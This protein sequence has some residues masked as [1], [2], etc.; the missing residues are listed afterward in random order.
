MALARDRFPLAR[1]RPISL[2]VWASFFSASRLHVRPPF[3]MNSRIRLRSSPRFR[4]SA[5]DSFL[6]PTAGRRR[7]PCRDWGFHSG[8]VRR[9]HFI[10]CDRHLRSHDAARACNA[11]QRARTPAVPGGQA[12]DASRLW[13]RRSI[14]CTMRRCDGRYSFRCCR[15]VS[16]LLTV[17][18]PRNG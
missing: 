18:S 1:R 3:G 9:S 17:G 10:K 5:R 15:R 12:P 13:P 7:G 2:R 6:S 16:W 14:P 4:A 11:K 8:G